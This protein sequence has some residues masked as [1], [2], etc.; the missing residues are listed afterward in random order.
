[1]TVI[2]GP[3]NESSSGSV[4][5]GG[6]PP[7]PRLQGHHVDWGREGQDSDDDGDCD[8]DDDDGDCDDDDDDGDGDD[9]GD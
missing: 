6:S 5:T 9:D 2:C 8:D 7:V 4:G 3:Y 1:M